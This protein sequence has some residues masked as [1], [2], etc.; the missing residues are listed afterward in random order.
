MPETGERSI[1]KRS[2][3]ARNHLKHQRKSAAIKHQLNTTCFD[4][5]L[6]SLVSGFNREGSTWRHHFE[7]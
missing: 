5:D 7:C 6:A 2:H 4:P 3:A 1:E